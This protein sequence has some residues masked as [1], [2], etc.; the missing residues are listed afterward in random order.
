MKLSQALKHTE[1][2]IESRPV[3]ALRAQLAY[4][5][6]EFCRESMEEIRTYTVK[7]ILVHWSWESMWTLA[8]ADH[9][10]WILAGYD[11]DY[12]SR[13]ESDIAAFRD[14]YKLVQ[15][16]IQQWE[17]L[18]HLAHQLHDPEQPLPREEF[19]ARSQAVDASFH[20]V[21]HTFDPDSLPDCLWQ[22]KADGLKLV[23]EWSLAT[24]NPPVTWT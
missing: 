6:C 22:I 14:A 16:T 19:L 4:K 17:E 2:Q 15:K 24:W 23:Q 20:P 13:L 10:P 7:D 18:Y 11:L 1:S 3:A 5:H 12:V 9:R 8:C 21:M